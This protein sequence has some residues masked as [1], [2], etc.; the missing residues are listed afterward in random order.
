M[1]LVLV[2]SIGKLTDE[3]ESARRSPPFSA[4]TSRFRA[5]TV[6]LWG[7]FKVVAGKRTSSLDRSQCRYN[8]G[9]SSLPGWWQTSQ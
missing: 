4:A 3:D 2:L 9:L 1:Y 6:S 7:R 5:E 8:F